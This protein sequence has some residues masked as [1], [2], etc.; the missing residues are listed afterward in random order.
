M[1]TVTR[2]GRLV[3]IPADPEPPPTVVGRFGSIMKALMKA[4]GER[5][6][7]IPDAILVHIYYRIHLI[8]KRFT[9]L[10]ARVE[11]GAVRPYR[12]RPPREAGEDAAASG[13]NKPPPPD[14]YNRPLRFPR[15][16]AWVVRY[17]PY[18]AAAFGSQ[19]AVLFN[20]PDMA[21]LVA[22]S[23][24]LRRMLRPL[25]RALAQHPHPALR[26]PPPQT[27]PCAPA[28]GAPPA[29][30]SAAQAAVAPARAPICGAPICGAPSSPAPVATRTPMTQAGAIPWPPETTDIAIPGCAISRG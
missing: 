7:K 11:A 19:L 2:D 25:M 21:K 13:E 4:V 18:D 9:A 22:R 27:R 10:A 23:P 1:I 16:W 6:G 5:S 24:G 15:D 8:L 14:P 30:G 3:T 17:V 26:D 29:P 28:D 12:P 20:D